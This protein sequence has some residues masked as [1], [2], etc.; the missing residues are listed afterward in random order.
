MPSNQPLPPAVETLAATEARRTWSQLLN[1]VHRE[2]GRVLIE[3]NGVPVAA[4]ISP[5]DLDFLLAELERRERAWQVIERAREAFADVPSD[6]IE[7]EV[8][9]AIAEVRAEQRSAEALAGDYS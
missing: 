3:K 1:R 6:E 4:L 8:A 5:R 2:R 9:K 7:R